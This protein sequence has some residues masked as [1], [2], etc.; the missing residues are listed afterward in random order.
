MKLHEKIKHFREL[1][2][3][4]QENVA[5]ELG[6]NQSQYSRRE[7]GNIKF[8]SDEISKLSQVLE[9]SMTDLFTDESTIFNNNNQKGGFFGQNINI[10]TELIEQYELRLREKDELIKSLKETIE[11]MK[12]SSK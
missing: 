4:S 2:K 11:L 5:Y 6:L 8:N 9:V 12:K 7:N 3:L 1:K 10:P